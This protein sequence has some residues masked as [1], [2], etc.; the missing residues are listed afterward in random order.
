MKWPGVIQT[1]TKQYGMTISDGEVSEMSF[2][3]K[4]SWLRRNPVTAARHFQYRID[5]FFQDFLKSKHKPLGELTDYAI[6]IEFQARGSPHAHTLIWIKDAPKYGISSD[7]E[8]C[9]FIDQYISCNIPIEE[10]PLRDLV[11][12]LQ[13]HRHSS[14]CKK[15]QSMSLSFSFASKP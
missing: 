8:V 12:L 7:Q 5:T 11:L 15:R 2:D 14:Y 13:K 6:R 10:G 9:D 4:S 1:I 3:E